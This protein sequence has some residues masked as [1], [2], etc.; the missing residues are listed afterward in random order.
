MK[1]TLFVISLFVL[2]IFSAKSF[3]AQESNF[4]FTPLKPTQGSTITVTYNPEKTP[5]K[6]SSSVNMIVCAYGK[7]V[8]NKEEVELKK[9]GNIWKGQFAVSDTSMGVIILFA[10]GEVKDINNNKKG[11]VINLFGK[12]GKEIPGTYAGLGYAYG[13]WISVLDLD[14]DQ[15]AAAKLLEKE[16]SVNPAVKKDFLSFYLNIINST[17]KEKGKEKI[18]AELKSLGENQNLKEAD[19]SLLISWFDRLKDVESSTKY[20]SLVAEKFPNGQYVQSQKFMALRQAKELEQKIKLADE[21]SSAYPKGVY[22]ANV[23]YEVLRGLMQAGKYSDAK[24]FLFNKYSNVTA[25]NYNTLAWAMFEKNTELEI[26]LD[27]ARKGVELARK[28]I[29]NPSQSKPTYYSKKDWE[30]ASKNSL[31]MI[32]DTYGV[33]LNKLGKKSESLSALEEAAS[34]SDFKDPGVNENYAMI[35]M[36][37]GNYKK[38][39]TEIEGFIAKGSGTPKMKEMIKE[40]YVKIN[41]SDK[42]FNAYF[43]KFEEAAKAKM[44]SKLKKELIDEPA[45][46]FTLLDLEGKNVSLTDFKGK[47]VIVDFWATWCGPCLASFPGMKQAVELYEKTGKAKFLF[48]NTWENVENKKQNA[49]DFI[50]KNNYPFHVLMDEKNDVITSYKVSGIPT[51]FII[52]KNGKIRF[53]SVGFGGNAD[54]MVEEIGIMI[55][56]IQ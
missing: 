18:L 47:P 12:D 6:E 22:I 27:V 35:L 11:Y 23:N 3:F 2:I 10:S 24:E 36:E 54:E 55:E 51:K 20:K 1:K 17:E 9:N 21:Y 16:F 32:M 19:Y 30:R 50:A 49:A 29:V 31:G 37:N 44:I 34:L 4:S 25:G 13:S 53:K 43:A 56:M 28:E 52:D 33:I 45:P 46:Q 41:G 48:V 15:E 8:D 38:A 39:Q 7:F 5:L 40:A 14:T 42:E 26:A